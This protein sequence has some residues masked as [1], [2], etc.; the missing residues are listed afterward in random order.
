MDLESVSAVRWRPAHAPLHAVVLAV[1][2]SFA[3]TSAAHDVEEGEDVAAATPSSGFVLLPDYT[4]FE[5]LSADPRWPRFSVSY[6]DFR[7]DAELD[8]VGSVAMGGSI[9]LFHAPLPFE[10]LWELGVQ[11]GVFSIFDLDSD[12]ND[13]INTDF[14]VGIPL[15]A[16]WGFFSFTIRPHHQSSHLGDEYLLRGPADRID[17]SFEAVDGILSFDLWTWGRIYGGGG[18]LVDRDPETLGRKYVQAGVELNGPL[19]FGVFR[20]I[21]MGDF[22]RRENSDWRTDYSA[23]AGIQFESRR[24]GRRRLQLLAEYYKG[25]NPNGQFFDRRIEYAGVG[26]HLHF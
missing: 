11:A 8:S 16:R 5:T 26:L 23:R 21:A 3:G 25:R 6:L 2:L 14:W 9:P 1:A 19:W 13:L 7:D 18:Y 24:L 4:L 22:Q 17:I 10:G 15:S 20:P 12:S